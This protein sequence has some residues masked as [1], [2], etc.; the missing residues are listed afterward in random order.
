MIGRDPFDG[1]CWSGSGT[2]FF[3]A[4][5]DQGL[6]A[7]AFGVEAPAHVRLPLLALN[8]AS[9]RTVWRKKFYLDTRYYRALTD[10]VRRKL[11]PDDL[12]HPIL[13]LGAI[14]NVPEI[15][16]GRTPCYSY[17]DGNLAEMVASPFWPGGVSARTIERARAYERDVYEGMHRIFTMSE[18]LRRSMVEQFGVPERKVVCIGAG[19]NL[20][21]IPRVDGK[22]YTRKTLLFVGVDFFRKGGNTLLEA[23]RIV[24]E[25][26]PDASLH[27]V[28]PRALSLPRERSRGVVYHGFLDKRVPGELRKLQRLWRDACLFVLPSDYEP[29]GIVALEAQ[30]HAI[31]CVLTDQWAFPEMV[32]PGVNGELVACGDAGRLAEALGSLLEDPSRL[33]RMGARAR[34]FAVDNYTW[35]AVVRRLSRHMGLEGDPRPAPRPAAGP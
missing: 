33:E 20:A 30:M 31:P 19:V 32:Q 7:R 26:H 29:F 27:L 35:E 11:T 22:D 16:R 4:C 23:F 1:Q 3:N 34:R 14:Y 13:Q 15:V 25:R 17:H 6:L 5:R 10:A 2:Y 28:G 18:Y 8:Y 12:G 24:R 9:N 21:R